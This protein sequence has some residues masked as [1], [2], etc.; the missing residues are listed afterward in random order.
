MLSL[1]NRYPHIPLTPAVSRFHFHQAACVPVSYTHLPAELF[2]C[3]GSVRVAGGDIAGAAVSDYVRDFNAGC[4]FEVLYDIEDAVAFAG[5]QVVDV[6]AGFVFDFLKGLYVSPG[7]VYYVDII[8]DAGSVGGVVVVAEYVK[9]FQLAYGNLGDV[10]HQV[11]G[12]AV[13]VLADGSALMGTDGI[14]I[15]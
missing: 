8:S 9:L 11:I 15:A 2:F 12:D 5:A 6:E 1:Q 7:Q 10:G 4:F 14:E 3:F 13:G